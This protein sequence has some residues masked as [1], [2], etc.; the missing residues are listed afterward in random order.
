MT[1]SRKRLVKYIKAVLP[2]LSRGQEHT[3]QSGRRSSL[4][5][6]RLS[7][8]QRPLSDPSWGGVTPGAGE[9]VGGRGVFVPGEG[10]TTGRGYG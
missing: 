7:A 8:G 3:G 6:G 4:T 1:S 10:P 2:S 9:D 5:S